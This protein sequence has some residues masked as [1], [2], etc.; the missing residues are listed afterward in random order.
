MNG[1]NTGRAF[2]VA[3]CIAAF[4]AL[5]QPVMAAD[6]KPPYATL[7]EFDSKYPAFD[8]NAAKQEGAKLAEEKYKPVKF[9]DEVVVVSKIGQSVRGQFRGLTSSGGVKVGDSVI[10]RTDLGDDDKIRF[11]GG[12]TETVRKKFV[13]DY[14]RG[15]K[16]A[17]QTTR[18]GKR[19]EAAKDI[20]AKN[21]DALLKTGGTLYTGTKVLSSDEIKAVVRHSAG[22][23]TICYSQLEASSLAKI[24]GGGRITTVSGTGY[25]GVKITSLDGGKLVFYDSGMKRYEMNTADLS[26]ESLKKLGIT[27][28][29][30]VKPPEAK[31][32]GPLAYKGKT[33]ALTNEDV[34][35]IQDDS[36]KILKKIAANPVAA[37]SDFKGERFRCRG[38]VVS[39]KE[40]VDKGGKAIIGSLITVCA[41]ITREQ[42]LEIDKTKDIYVEG[43]VLDLMDIG[44]GNYAVALDVEKCES[45]DR[46]KRNVK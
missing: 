13:E 28:E 24:K 7:E 44:D 10:S 32:S 19:F 34:L 39:M 40:D 42:L 6:A 14:V 4:A 5:G 11:S 22:T 9:G 38:Y 35:S 8:E 1:R 36:V 17:Y 16:S 37:R 29:Q 3:G 2:L 12:D 46:M 20:E 41:F 45:L 30:A 43:T 27:R 23:D 31:K 21:P 15:R 26:D 25:E 18:T 33:V